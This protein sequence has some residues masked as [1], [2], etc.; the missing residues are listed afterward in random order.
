VSCEHRFGTPHYATVHTCDRCGLSELEAHRIQASR[1]SGALCDASTVVV[2]P[3]EQGIHELTHERDTY[4]S[5][6]CDFVACMSPAPNW[7]S[8]ELEVWTKAK[9]LLKEG[10]TRLA[11]NGSE[12][13]KGSS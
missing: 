4:R 5:M 13:P 2:D 1:I 10:P 11:S 6:V 9:R 8:K 3:A 12:T 7:P